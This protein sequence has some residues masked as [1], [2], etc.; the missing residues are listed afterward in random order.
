MTLV[1]EK[2]DEAGVLVEN[3]IKKILRN[4]G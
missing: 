4:Q 2:L 1:K 3:T